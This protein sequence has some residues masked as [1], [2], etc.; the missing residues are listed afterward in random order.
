MS[1][2]CT[3]IVVRGRGR[4]DAADLA[5]HLH[6]S[7][8]DDVT[9]D[10]ARLDFIGPVGLVAIAVVAEKAH[11]SGNNVRFIEPDNV[12]RAAG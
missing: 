3:D 12:D 9:I 4:L 1:D 11:S 2:T 8:N 6:P 10:L 7:R 5:Q